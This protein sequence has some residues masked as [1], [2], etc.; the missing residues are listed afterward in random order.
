M[1]VQII[2]GWAFSNILIQNKTGYGGA[3]GNRIRMVL[4]ALLY[5]IKNKIEDKRVF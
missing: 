4:Y 2:C 1:P 5:F 3:I